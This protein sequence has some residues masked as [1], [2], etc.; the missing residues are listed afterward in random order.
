MKERLQKL[1][2][3]A[4]IGSR[5]TSEDLITKGRVRVNGVTA[6]LGD[7]AD[8]ATDVIEVDGARL[9]FDAQP[10]IYIMLNKPK[11]VLTTD[12]PHRGDRRET[13]AG[14]IGR[15]EHLFS[16][17]RLDAD[18]EGLVV[19]TNDGDLSQK[20]S[21]PRYRHSK[22]YKVEVLGLPTAETL[23]RWQEGIFLDDGK[24]APCLVDITKGSV[25][26]TTLRIVMTEGKKRQIR[27]VAAALGHPVQ[28][29][30]R[31]HIGLL[32]L[33]DLEPGQ[34]RPLNAKE[35][36]ALSTPA[37]E[38]KTLRGKQRR[39]GTEK[40]AAPAAEEVQ[41]KRPSRRITL[42]SAD[43]MA[44]K[45]RP[46]R[47]GVEVSSYEADAKRRKPRASTSGDEEPEKRR[48][49]RSQ[50]A[51]ADDDEE[52][53]R[54]RRTPRTKPAASAAK[55]VGKRRTP[56]A[57]SA[58]AGN[59]PETRSAAPEEAPKKHIRRMRR[60]ADLGKPAPR[61]RASDEEAP[62]R[63]TSRVKSTTSS[64]EAPDRRRNSRSKPFTS[65]DDEKPTKR[66]PSRT[67]TSGSSDDEKPA[68]RRTSRVKPAASPDAESS[69]SRK[70]RTRKGNSHDDKW[71]KP[72]PASRDRKP[73]RK[74]D[75][76][77]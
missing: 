34:S 45:H 33:G 24:T 76:P 73:R 29:L 65:S 52:T 2:A 20:L 55:N 57:A 64:D 67:R 61:I 7:K 10:H 44:E 36:V 31:T 53:P 28:R 27:R 22:T 3:Q 47:R 66:P 23:E 11:Q 26:G 46:T 39:S 14:L 38:I 4:N 60:P 21:H 69:K 77:R 59:V 18:S 68:K 40:E 63:R 37:P 42:P 25:R 70:P 1:L 49:S 58:E 74:K 71:G 62:K 54:K 9:K 50:P 35:V 17:G 51:F 30:I 41:E 43:E 6:Q 16:I 72:S 19:M 32:A 56:R 15:D 75:S 8:P 12:K 5:R 48:T 13:V